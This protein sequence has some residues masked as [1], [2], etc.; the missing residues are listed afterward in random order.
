MIPHISATTELPLM[1]IR[2]R[3]SCMSTDTKF[4]TDMSL[5]IGGYSLSEEERVQKIQ[6]VNQAWFRYVYGP[7]RWMI[8][9]YKIA[10]SVGLIVII[11]GFPFGFNFDGSDDTKLRIGP[12]GTLE[13][14]DLD[15]NM[16]SLYIGLG[17]VVAG[18]F[19]MLFGFGFAVSYGKTAVLNKMD[20][21]LWIQRELL[22]KPIGNTQWQL[23]KVHTTIMA[24]TGAEVGNLYGIVIYPLITEAV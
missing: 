12:N 23:E 11:T 5:P 20:A 13:Y 19:I 15:I 1:V 2:E 16:D 7:N 8:N 21:Q 6:A 4:P 22:N 17:L 24:N 3:R 10:C 14:G 9:V 18:F